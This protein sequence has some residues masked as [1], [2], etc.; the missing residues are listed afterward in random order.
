MTSAVVALDIA[1]P[2][3]SL[4][5]LV[6]ARFKGIKGGRSGGK[7]HERA[8]ALI[9]AM[10]MDENLSAVC[11]REIQKS[12]KFSAKKL[13]EQK[14]AKFKVG[15]LFDITS[16]E[17]RRIGSDGKFK[18]VI[19]FQGLQ[20]HTADSI[21]SLEDFQIAWV[22]EA[23]TLSAKSMQLLIPT[24][25][26]A[27]SELWF[28]WNPQDENNPVEQLFADAANDPDFVLVH[29]NFEQN[30]FC[31]EESKKEAARCARVDP[32]NYEHIWHG[33]YDIKSEAQVFSGKWQVEE[34]EL[35]ESWAPMFGADWGFSQ[36][37]TTAVECYV[38]DRTLYIR[39]EA[40]KL[41]L[42]LDQTAPYF[43]KCLPEI[44]KHTIRA[45]SAR[46][47]TISYLKNPA[48]GDDRL[49]M[50]ESVKKG[51]GSVA[52][53]ITH[54]RN[55]DRI[56]IHP[57]CPKT[58][59]EFKFYSYKV[60]KQTGDVLPEVKDAWNHCIDAIRYALQPLIKPDGF[61]FDC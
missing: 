45:D 25:R 7:S 55:Y 23:Q 59:E 54:M 8:E 2:R 29:V 11:I 37:P 52:D 41:A 4:P 30:P 28:T 16:T 38:N 58:A 61:V 5:L 48:R 20:D 35:D 46:P 42:E 12:L 19:I 17:I 51:A 39:R 49:P 10:V 44:A 24:I 60:N 21:K 26:A 43:K 14:I 36:D 31:T 9:E 13:L 15:H 47:E 40:W 27:G 56:V 22:E 1:T 33:A 18:G 50:I 32:E 6:A 53:G 3:W 34:F 57:D